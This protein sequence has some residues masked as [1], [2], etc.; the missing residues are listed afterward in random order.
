MKQIII[1]SFLLGMTLNLFAKASSS[2]E[3]DGLIFNLKDGWQLQTKE[4]NDKKILSIIF[5]TGETK[6]TLISTNMGRHVPSET[7]RDMLKIMVSTKTTEKVD[8][9]R[10]ISKTI[11]GY[12]FSSKNMMWEKYEKL[13]DGLFKY[14][15]WGYFSVGNYMVQ[16]NIGTNDI[17]SDSVKEA[18]SIINQIR[19]LR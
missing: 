14:E 12:Y 9:K 15:I 5:K 13:R 16:V 6:I 2:I 17:N 4:I 18:F 11:E 8:I 3:K 19:E 7:Y 1:F 10:F